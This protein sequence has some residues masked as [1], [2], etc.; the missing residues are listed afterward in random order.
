MF[1]EIMFQQ[2]SL[3]TAAELADIGSPKPIRFSENGLRATTVGIDLSLILTAVTFTPIIYLYAST[4]A[5]PG[6]SQFLKVAVE[7]GVVAVLFLIVQRS[8]D[9]QNLLSLQGQFWNYTQAWL[10]GFMVVLIEAFM[11]QTSA[12]YSR[13]GMLFAFVPGFALA[14]GARFGIF[15]ALR[16]RLLR[17]EI[18]VSSAFL[19]LLGER[20]DADMM[21]MRLRA[22]GIMVSGLSTIPTATLAGSDHQTEAVLAK[23]IQSARQVVASGRCDTIYVMAPWNM[24]KAVGRLQDLL[25]RLPVPVVL[26]PESFALDVVNARPVDIA[27]IPGLEIQRAPLAWS[28]RAGKRGFDVLV[29]GFGLLLLSPFLGL[30]ALGVLISSGRPILFRQ[31]RRGFAGR[32]FTILKFRTM[33]VAENGPVV[34]QAERN[35]PRITRFGA[36]LRKHSLDELPQIW[37]VLVGDMSLIGPRPHA[38]AHDDQYDPLIATYAMRH[39]VKPGIAGWAQINGH[40][41]ETPTVEAMEA[42]VAHDLWYI[43]HF[44]LRL[45]LYIVTKTVVLAFHDSAAY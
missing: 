13:G 2:K 18:V 41:G 10:L 40:R 20:R 5:N 16:R 3:A 43:N 37:N 21:V 28:E 38:E 1:E 19:V 32:S 17:H 7:S 44:S 45:D 25:R 26:L 23:T 39:H 34:R 9:F 33:R 12:D 24:E 22:R 27:G 6:F 31:H 35:D 15:H 36:F 4:G 11:T 14:C 8:Y 42:R 30:V 29:A